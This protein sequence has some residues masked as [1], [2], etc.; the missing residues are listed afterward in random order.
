LIPALALASPISVADTIGL[1]AADASSAILMPHSSA[2]VASGDAGLAMQVED[3]IYGIVA[4]GAAQVQ[5]VAKA[6]CI[7]LKGVAGNDLVASQL[8]NTALAVSGVKEVK[9]ELK[10]SAS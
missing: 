5:V 3:A 6:G 7:T 8:V 2:P 9:T 10:F 1:Y 4:S